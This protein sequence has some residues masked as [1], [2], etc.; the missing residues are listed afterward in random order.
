MQGALSNKKACGA[1]CKAP[2]NTYFAVTINTISAEPQQAA[3]DVLLPPVGT[4]P[5]LGLVNG[6]PPQSISAPKSI[7]NPPLSSE[8][9]A[10]ASKLP[11]PSSLLPAPCSQFPAHCSQLPAPSSQFPAHCS[12]LPAPCSQLIA[13]SSQ[14]DPGQLTAAC[15]LPII[16]A[17]NPF[18]YLWGGGLR[19]DDYSEGVSMLS[20]SE[21]RPSKRGTLGAIE[22]SCFC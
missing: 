18:N 3:C 22:K 21:D 2:H 16:L 7:R 15:L 10:P 17:A 12:Q 1:P 5:H 11:A 9:P 19:N 4:N 20:Y 8:L 14:R 13:P 6:S